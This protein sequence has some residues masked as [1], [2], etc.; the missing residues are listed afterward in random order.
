MVNY[1]VSVTTLGLLSESAF[2]GLER[3]YT[4]RQNMGFLYKKT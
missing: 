4:M 1:T 3:S 2:Q